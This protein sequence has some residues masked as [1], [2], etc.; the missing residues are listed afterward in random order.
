MRCE[1][2]RAMNDQQ[3]ELHMEMLERILNKL[4]EIRCGLIDVEDAT[5]SC[6][7]PNPVYEGYQ[8]G[9]ICKSCGER[10]G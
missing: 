7:H 9:W 2:K 8:V 3:F 5:A 1:K 4:E 6:K 10:V